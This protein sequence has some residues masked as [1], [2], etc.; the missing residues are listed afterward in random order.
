MNVIR[1]PG[2]PGWVLEAETWI[3][4]PRTEVFAFFADAFQLEAITPPWLHFE[5]TTPQP[6][7]LRQGSLID[8]RLKLRGIPMKWRSEITVW[9]P[10]YRFVD[11]QRRGPY[12]LWR[13]EHAFEERDGGTLCRDRVTYDVP[14]GWLVNKLLV[15]RDVERI[16]RFRD[17]RMKEIFAAQKPAAAP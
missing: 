13:H 12:K 5:V 6:I 9:E 15:Q 14:G 3:D 16:F 17:Q 4:R 10:P 8:Y 11:E 7:D 1:N 2:A